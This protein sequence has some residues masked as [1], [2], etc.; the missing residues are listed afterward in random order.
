MVSSFY[1]AG[2]KLYVSE[3]GKSGQTVSGTNYHYRIDCT[4]IFTHII[5][6]LYH[7]M[8]WLITTTS[9]PI[10]VQPQLQTFPLPTLL[11]PQIWRPSNWN[12][13]KPNHIN[14]IILRGV[15]FSSYISA[16][17]QWRHPVKSADIT[18]HY[19]CHAKL[20]TASSLHRVKERDPRRKTPKNGAKMFRII[21]VMHPPKR[22]LE[23]VYLWAVEVTA[24]AWENPLNQL[25]L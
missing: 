9:T 7:Y 21:S 18:K 6:V 20:K 2:L 23:R 8:H 17:V 15:S 25:R 16:K 5:R 13:T 22:E 10:D 12:S 19:I 11:L 14:H 4:Q 3:K 24:N 1:R